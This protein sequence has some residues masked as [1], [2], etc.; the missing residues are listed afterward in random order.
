MKVCTRLTATSPQNA[1]ALVIKGSHVV[2]RDPGRGASCQGARLK[3]RPFSLLP[4]YQVLQPRALLRPRETILPFP[5]I[6][7]FSS[8]PIELNYYLNV[9][10]STCYA[11]R[12]Y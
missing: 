10:H 4:A 8:V 5:L 6:L 12:G 1:I 9:A 7:L 11:T 2:P 3:L